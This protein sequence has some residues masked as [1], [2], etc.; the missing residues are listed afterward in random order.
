MFEFYKLTK[1]R[2]STQRF[3]WTWVVIFEVCFS[4]SRAL[5]AYLSGVGVPCGEWI[6][7]RVAVRPKSFMHTVKCFVFGRR[8]FLWGCS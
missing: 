7:G 1:M 4:G 3:V 2:M 6:F 5:L 8:C